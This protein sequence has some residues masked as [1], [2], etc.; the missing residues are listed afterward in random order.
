[1]M[2]P[3]A[4]HHRHE[5]DG[6]RR[7]RLRRAALQEDVARVGYEARAVAR[8]YDGGG[9]EEVEAL[10]AQHLPRGEAPAGR[11]CADVRLLLRRQDEGQAYEGRGQQQR[12]SEDVGEMPA[13][14]GG[15]D[16]L[17]RQAAQHEGAGPVA[18]QQHAGGKALLV[19]KARH[20]GGEHAVIHKAHAYARNGEGDEQ[21]PEAVGRRNMHSR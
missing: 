12:A 9:E 20:D 10:R 4:V 18:H 8:A 16:E 13:E 1:M 7:R 2:R 15:G 17:G 21:Q 3:Q 5:A 11:G 19:R 14:A 6:Q